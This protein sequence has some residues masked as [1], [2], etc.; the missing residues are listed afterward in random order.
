MTLIPVLDDSLT[1]GGMNDVGEI[2]GMRT[3]GS[4]QGFRWKATSGIRFGPIGA[5]ATG[6]NNKGEATLFVAGPTSE[7]VSIWD[8]GGTVRP[9]RPLS[10]FP[11]RFPVCAPVGIITS[12]VVFGWC[13]VGNAAIPKPTLWTAFGTPWALTPEG[14]T[15]F[16]GFANAMSDGG[17]VGGNGVV[18]GNAGP[19][20]FDTPH[21]QLHPL[22]GNGSVLAVNDSSLA[23]G[24][25][26]N[27]TVSCRENPVVWSA[28]GTAQ[29]LGICG[30]AV[31]VSPDG[32][33]VGNA[34]HYVTDSSTAHADYAWTWTSQRGIT[35]LPVPNAGD[36]AAI[37]SINHVHQI[38]GYIVTP[39]GRRHTALWTLTP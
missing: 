31:G 35:K 27:S 14:G 20:I 30:R 28:T 10:S 17:I 24:F 33:V 23:A 25:A 8:E 2:V 13:Q 9:L 22:P 29:N 3:N 5:G 34:F 12:G 11:V 15:S 38:L 1:V 36:G 18:P 4:S 6:V 32:L 19:Y 21:H 37:V 26:V 39:D 16:P 7:S